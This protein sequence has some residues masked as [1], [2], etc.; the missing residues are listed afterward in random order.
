[1]MRS[2]M[3][4]IIRHGHPCLSASVY[5]VALGSTSSPMGSPR[6]FSM[7]PVELPK[8]SKYKTTITKVALSISTLTTG[9]THGPNSVTSTKEMPPRR[10]ECHIM[11]KCFHEIMCSFSF[12]KRL[13]TKRLMKLESKP[14]GRIA[15]TRAT[16]QKPDKK[17][18]SFNPRPPVVTA[19]MPMTPENKKISVSANDDICF[20]KKLAKAMLSLDKWTAEYE[21]MMMELNNTAI[22]PENSSNSPNAKVKKQDT[23]IMSTACAGDAPVCPKRKTRMARTA[24]DTPTNTDPKNTFNMPAAS[25]AMEPTPCS[26]TDRKSVIATASLICD[27]PKTRM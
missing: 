17:R 25:I 8:R 26:F 16:R 22:I 20:N 7:S 11:T 6:H 18:P 5:N 27:S 13:P 15:K 24:K 3:A 12:G 19:K 9:S 21:P 23:N 4:T 10:P 1:M 2:R 14:I